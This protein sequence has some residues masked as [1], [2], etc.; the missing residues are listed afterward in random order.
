M[1]RDRKE[2]VCE[3]DGTRFLLIDTGGVD[4]ADASPITRGDRRP[5]A[6]RGRGGRSRPLRRRRAGRHHPRRRGAGR[7]SSALARKPVIVLA[8]KIDD[9]ARTRSRT[10]STGSA[11]ASRSRSRRS[12]GTGPATCST[13]SSTRLPGGAAA[14]IPEEAIRVADP[15]P[16][17][18]RQVEPAERAARRGA[19]HRL[20]RARARRATRS[21]RCCERGDRTFVLV[22]TAGPAPQAP[23][24]PGH[25]VLLGAARAGGGRARRRGARPRRRERGVVDQDLAVAD[26]ARKAQCSTL[27][28]L[29]KWDVST[30]GDR[31]RAA[32]AGGR[33][34]QR[35]PVAAVSATDEARD[36]ARCSTGS[37]SCSTSTRTGSRPPS[38]TASSA[39]CARPRSRPPQRQAAQ[40]AVRHAGADAPAALPLLRQRSRPD[41]ARLRLLGREPAARAVR[42]EGVPVSIDF[43]RRG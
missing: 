13:R 20:R 28:V 37:R 14:E 18:R 33:L 38:S 25:R 19:R 11:S 40:P 26:V 36:G 39:S 42:L 2:L 22:D 6:G 3:W 7:R 34:R 4:I 1:T 21:T 17:E 16:A 12:T 29:S 5:G 41:H 9:P 10:S 31:G 35:P 23:A 27:V 30:V 43:V 8:N 32:A 15:R 24:A